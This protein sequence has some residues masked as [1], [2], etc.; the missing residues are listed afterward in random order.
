M[1]TIDINKVIDKIKSKLSMNNYQ[2]PF[3]NIL[4]IGYA[5]IRDEAYMDAIE[6]IRENI[7]ETDKYDLI[8]KRMLDIYL[9]T[10][11]KIKYEYIDEHESRLKGKYK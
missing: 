8:A 10:P 11:I 2:D 4:E 9:N 3:R 5:K 6:I 7:K 1:K